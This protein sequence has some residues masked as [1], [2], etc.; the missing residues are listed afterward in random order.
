MG[1]SVKKGPYVEPSLLEKLRVV[2]E[3]R[4]LDEKH[5]N[6]VVK[7]WWRRSSIRP[8]FVGVLVLG[9]AH[10]LNP[11]FSFF[12]LST[13]IFSRSDGSTKK[14]GCSTR[15]TRRRCSRRGRG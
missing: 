9:R 3:R 12:S 8:D 7:M 14:S 6:K 15:R 5:E 2:N 1:R 10:V 13:R 4:V 11:F